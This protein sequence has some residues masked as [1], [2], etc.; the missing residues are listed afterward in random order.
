MGG[1]KFVSG[2]G[3]RTLEHMQP[4]TCMLLGTMCRA[5]LWLLVW[6][7][8]IHMLSHCEEVMIRATNDIQ[9]VMRVELVYIPTRSTTT[10]IRYTIWD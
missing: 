4:D 1:G 6:C 2:E 8:D 10:S 5:C 9:K 3:V 7:N